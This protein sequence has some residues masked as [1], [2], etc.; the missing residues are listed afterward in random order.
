VKNTCAVKYC[1]DRWF[2]IC[3]PVVASN[4]GK[5]TKSLSRPYVFHSPLTNFRDSVGRELPVNTE[6]CFVNNA[7]RVHFC[8]NITVVISFRGRSITLCN[9]LQEQRFHVL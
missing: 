6:F 2:H 9:L 8:K 5:P 4:E 1:N 3:S 7:L